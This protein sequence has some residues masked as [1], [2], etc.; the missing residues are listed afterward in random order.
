MVCS[1]FRSCIS[2]KMLSSFFLSRIL[3]FF[4]SLQLFHQ[5]SIWLSN[6]LINFIFKPPIDMVPDIW[7][8]PFV[9]RRTL[10]NILHAEL[11]V[12]H[13]PNGLDM[14]NLFPS[15]CT[16]PG[17]RRSLCPSHGNIYC[18]FWWPN[19]SMACIRDA[20]TQTVSVHSAA[21]CVH[22]RNLRR[23]PL[24]LHWVPYGLEELQPELV[25][26]L[27]GTLHGV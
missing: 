11:T 15:R 25:L 5:I 8:R 12:L 21:D 7:M 10:G 9:Y 13:I 23:Y 6:P 14:A 26:L 1:C 16:I 27:L 17:T 22:R 19:M 18:I 2:S 4:F 20:D 24:F 3:F